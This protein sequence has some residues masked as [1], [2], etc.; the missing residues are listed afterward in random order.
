[1]LNMSFSYFA[2]LNLEIYYVNN[3][4]QSKYT[5]YISS[6]NIIYFELK[7][8]TQKKYFSPSNISLT[9]DNII[10]LFSCCQERNHSMLPHTE[11]PDT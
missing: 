8:F 2:M 4:E 9:R 10:T 1:M 11:V 3:M 6:L 5:S 7:I